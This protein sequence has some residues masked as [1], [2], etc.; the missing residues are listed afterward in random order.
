MLLCV[1][2]RRAVS[3]SMFPPDGVCSHTFYAHVVLKDGDISD[4]RAN[5]TAGLGAFLDVART[6]NRTGFGISFD[7]R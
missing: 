1:V 2:G 3:Q 6:S 5:T 4:S 7:F